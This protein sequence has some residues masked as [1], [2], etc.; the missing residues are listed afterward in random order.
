VQ[1]LP[2]FLSV[3]E[4]CALFRVDRSTI[5]NQRAGGQPPGNLGIRIGK[6]Y[7]YPV[8]AVLDYLETLGIPRGDSEAWI[9]SQ[10]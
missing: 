7:R 5:E 8:S 1:D 10:G 3:D 4:V 6:H 2:L 9:L